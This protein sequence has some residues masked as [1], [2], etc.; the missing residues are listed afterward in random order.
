[1]EALKTP[2]T[3]NQLQT[4][5]WL[6]DESDAARQHK[7]SVQVSNLKDLLDLNLMEKD[8]NTHQRFSG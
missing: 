2:E 6:T 5:G 8:R 7:Q 1:M 4:L 3:L